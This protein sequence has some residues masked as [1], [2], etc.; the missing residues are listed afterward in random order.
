[1]KIEEISKVFQS[2][3]PEDINDYLSKGYSIIKIFSTKVTS[4]NCEQICPTYILGLK[5]EKVD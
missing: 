3:N 4:D 2:T 1:M 5:K